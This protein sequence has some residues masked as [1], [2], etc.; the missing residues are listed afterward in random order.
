MH[1]GRAGHKF[2]ILFRNRQNLVFGKQVLADVAAVLMLFAFS[3]DD[4]IRL[5]H[6]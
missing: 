1:A 6:S 2:S 5:E 4:K 3:D